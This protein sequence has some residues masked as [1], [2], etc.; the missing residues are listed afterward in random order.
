[1][2]L[3]QTFHCGSMTLSEVKHYPH[4]LLSQKLPPRLMGKVIPQM[5]CIGPPDLKC[6]A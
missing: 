6:H 2:R 5:P 1:M 4:Q 3:A